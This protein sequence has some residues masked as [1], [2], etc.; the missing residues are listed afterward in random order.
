MTD[1]LEIYFVQWN[2]GN[3]SWPDIPVYCM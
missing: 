3:C 1:Q 2:W